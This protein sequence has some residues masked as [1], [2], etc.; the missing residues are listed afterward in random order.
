MCR[1]EVSVLDGPVRQ[2]TV[3][4]GRFRRVRADVLTAEE[5]LTVEL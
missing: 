2:V 4:G 3:L 5:G 1:R